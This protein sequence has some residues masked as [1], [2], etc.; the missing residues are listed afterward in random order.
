MNYEIWIQIM[1]YFYKEGLSFALHMAAN[2]KV[3]TRKMKYS[4]KYEI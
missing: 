4:I 3:I 2:T 1:K